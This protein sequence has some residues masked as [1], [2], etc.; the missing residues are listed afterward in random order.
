M[1][2]L[3][4]IDLIKIDIV[5]H[6]GKRAPCSTAFFLFGCVAAAGGVGKFCGC[7]RTALQRQQCSQKKGNQIGMRVAIFL[8]RRKY[9]HLHIL[10]FIK[11]KWY[12]YTSC[13]LLLINKHMSQKKNSTLNTFFFEGSNTSA[14][15]TAS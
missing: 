7:C 5:W 9:I 1:L 11:I 14:L 8:G 2:I 6:L 4:C 15:N 13:N 10:L 12:N 3:F